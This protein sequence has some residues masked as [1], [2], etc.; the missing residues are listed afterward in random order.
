MKTTKRKFL[1]AALSAWPVAALASAG[2]AGAAR[3]K[4]RF[5]KY[6]EYTKLVAIEL[7]IIDMVRDAQRTVL[8]T[9][10]RPVPVHEARHEL[11]VAFEQH[12]AEH[13]LMRTFGRS[14]SGT[15]VQTS[16]SYA[17]IE[18]TQILRSHGVV[19][20]LIGTVA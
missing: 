20:H 11:A 7:R 14:P 1:V 19:L 17:G 4:D 16:Q 15:W 10:N 6:A 18:S 12:D 8:V 13:V 9:S 3:T 2:I 5:S